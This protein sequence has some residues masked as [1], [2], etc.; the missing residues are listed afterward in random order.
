MGSGI[1]FVEFV[2]VNAV[3]NHPSFRD[4]E[5]EL[6]SPSGAIS[7]LSVPYDSTEKYPL[8]GGFRFGSA[9]HLGESA[10]GTWTLRVSDN[11]TGDNAGVLDSWG[12][13][14][15]GHSDGCRCPIHHVGDPRQ[16]HPRCRLGWPQPASPGVTAYDLRHI[17]TSADEMVDAD[18]TLT[19]NAWTSASSELWYKLEG[20]TDGTEYDVQVRAVAS[21]VDGAWSATE[22]GTPGASSSTAPALSTR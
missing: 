9:R 20:L 5:V 12:I 7:T 10:A 16:R 6:V 21:G 11:V 2:E 14:V 18:W 15:Y 1:D 4:L 17:E 19:D 3:F 8:A 13:T 22:T